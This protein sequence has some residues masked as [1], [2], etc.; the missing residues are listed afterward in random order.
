MPRVARAAKYALI[1]FAAVFATLLAVPRHRDP[2]RGPPLEPW[3]AYVPRRVA[4]AAELD[5]ADW[6]RYIEAENHIFE[7]LRTR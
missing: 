7:A 1:A 3:H 2:Q 6:P 4:C 5:R